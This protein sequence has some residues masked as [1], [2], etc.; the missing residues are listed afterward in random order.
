M[1]NKEFE[2][3]GLNILKNPTPENALEFWQFFKKAPPVKETVML[4][5][6]HKARLQHPAFTNE[7]RE[8]SKKWLSENGYKPSYVS[9]LG[10]GAA[11]H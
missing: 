9:P 8:V 6:I 3:W 4:A 7:E 11:G 10:D 2:D 1:T 5:G